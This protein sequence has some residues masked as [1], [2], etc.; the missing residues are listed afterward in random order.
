M[1]A[2]LALR[3][4]AALFGLIG[5]A[6]VLALAGP[7]AAGIT[8]S[9]FL[10]GLASGE[11]HHLRFSGVETE[12]LS[13]ADAELMGLVIARGAEELASE[14][15]TPVR[16]PPRR[17]FRCECQG[18]A[19]GSGQSRTGL[20]DRTRHHALAAAVHACRKR[21]AAIRAT[22]SAAPAP[23]AVTFRRAYAARLAS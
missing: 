18:L 12:T 14:A 8:V 2:T 15:V 3:C 19:I 7:L 23:P 5:A 6:T 13:A 4:A 17:K 1:S 20:A 11:L 16:I 21:E 22:I 10:L 9:A